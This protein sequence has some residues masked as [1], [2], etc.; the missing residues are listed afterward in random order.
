MTITLYNNSSAYNTLYK[1]M[2]KLKDVTATIKGACSVDNPTL[3]IDNPG[4]AFNY[5]YIG[6]FGRYYKV[7]SRVLS[8]GQIMVISG[9]SDPVESFNTGIANLDVFINRAEDLSLRSPELSDSMIPLESD[10][11]IDKVIGDTVIGSG[12]GMVVIGVI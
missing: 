10:V 8:P 6:D 3:V 7:T 12:S 11:Q 5:F 2:T 9:V 1:S 4:I